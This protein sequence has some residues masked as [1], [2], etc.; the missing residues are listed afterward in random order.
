[1]DPEEVSGIILFY[2]NLLYFILSQSMISSLSSGGCVSV[3]AVGGVC[4]VPV[5]LL[6][7]QDPQQDLA[8]RQSKHLLGRADGQVVREPGCTGLGE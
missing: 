2:S 4:P 5:C 6:R 7:L 3:G 1:M 8:P